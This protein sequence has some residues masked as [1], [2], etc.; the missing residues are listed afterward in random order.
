MP[1]GYTFVAIS[2]KENNTMAATKNLCTQIPTDLHQRVCEAREQSGL[3]R[4]NAEGKDAIRAAVVELEKAG[5]IQ[6]RQTTDR[7]G[8]CGST[9]YVIREY[10]VTREPPLEGPSSV[11][12]QTEKP[13]QIN[14]DSRKTNN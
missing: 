12:T 5:Y 10:P 1:F 6:R 4:I 11:P 2:G 3:A 14:K 13:T 7:A 9:E 8:K